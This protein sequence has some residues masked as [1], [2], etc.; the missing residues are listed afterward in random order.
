LRS[1]NI[2][3]RQRSNPPQLNRKQLLNPRH[4]KKKQASK[5]VAPAQIKVKN[6]APA[7]PEITPEAKPDHS[8]VHHADEPEHQIPIP[9]PSQNLH[10]GMDHS[11]HI[12]PPVK[13]GDDTMLLV[14]LL[15]R[16]NMSHA[17]SRYLPMSRNGSGTSW[18]PDA[19]PMYGSMFM[20]RD[21]YFMAHGEVFLRYTNQDIFEAGTRG[22]SKFDAPNWF[23][24]MGQR[25]IGRRGLFHANLMLSLD[26]ITEKTGYPL[27]FQ[28]GETYKGKPL[29]DRQH[30]HDL[31]SELSIAYTHAF[32][33]NTDVTAYFGYPGEPT[34]GPTAFMHRISAMNNPD[35]PLGHHWQDASHI[36]FGVATLGFRYKKLKVEGSN[37]T[38]RE[39]DENRYNFDKPRFDSYSYRLQVAPSE[40]FVLQFSQGF[41]E[42]PEELQ[43]EEDVT[44]TTASVLYSKMLKP[45]THFTS[46]LIWGH[47]KKED[48]AEHSILLEGNY[49]CRKMAYYG[50][51]EFVQKDAE[52][53]Q[54]TEDHGGGEHA[55]GDLFNVQALT[56]GTNRILAKC[57]V[58]NLA[59]GL[60]ATI[61]RPDKDLHDVYGEWPISGQVYLRL[62]PNLM[63]MHH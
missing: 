61:Y 12:N 63:Q 25:E 48:H 57:C 9:A 55:H 52:E 22:D 38:G 51:Y 58:L 39:P 1:T 33:R 29:V 21:W 47:N 11:G 60:Q 6:P 32:S 56:L 42:S 8:P 37:F 14:D 28:S 30:P 17:F 35:A 15:L 7:Q 40:N 41:L 20:I 53:L 16:R 13:K 44:R 3:S 49:Q 24:L 18:N 5:T 45:E 31:I 43:P 50:R 36:Q 27:L 2:T 19:T 54:L 10:S 23:M 46:A 4:R 62:V 34:I 59:L 26:P